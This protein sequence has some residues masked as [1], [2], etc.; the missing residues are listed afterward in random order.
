MLF[1]LISESEKSDESSTKKI[2]SSEQEGS[3][4]PNL[5]RSALLQDDKFLDQITIALSDRLQSTSKARPI[6]SNWIYYDRGQPTTSST[7]VPDNTTPQDHFKNEKSENDLNDTFDEN[8]LLKFVPR[9]YKEKA[10]T[11]LQIFD[12]RPNELT[13]DNSGVIWIDQV[14][15]PNSNIYS[16]FPYL[17]RRKIPKDVLAKGFQ[18]FVQK[19]N[20]MNLG[21]LLNCK[22]IS[23]N[24]IIPN[25]SS[26]RKP[27]K[28][29][30]L[31]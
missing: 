21:H 1:I 23:E 22:K 9:N 6:T 8:I 15:I 20:Q 5:V 7:V 12:D 25:A 17:F 27:T 10:K 13:W 18:D 2:N 24:P 14:A 4:D 11:L 31:N 16:L 26:N 3:G 29:W 28:W 19:L 30:Y